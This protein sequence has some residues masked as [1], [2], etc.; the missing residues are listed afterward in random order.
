MTFGD[1]YHHFSHIEPFAPKTPY[2]LLP[3][4][5]GAGQQDGS[6]YS[7]AKEGWPR[8]QVNGPVP[9]KARTGWFVQLPMNRWLER[10]TPSAPAKEASPLFLNGRSHPS[11]AKEGSSIRMLRDIY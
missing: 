7:L 2:A 10:T 3:Y 8:H 5:Y 11:F 6:G 1:N 4:C 9:L